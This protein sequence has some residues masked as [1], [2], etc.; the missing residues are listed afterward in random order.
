M[1]SFDQVGNSATDMLADTGQNGAAAVPALRK[2]MFSTNFN[3]SRRAMIAVK[4]LGPVAADLYP[5]VHRLMSDRSWEVRADGACRD[6]RH[7]A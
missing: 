5:E 2:M 6:V 1:E 4:G 3:L 7:C